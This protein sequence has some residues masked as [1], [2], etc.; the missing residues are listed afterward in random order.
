LKILIT[1]RYDQEY[2]RNLILINGLK[3]KG[4]SIAEAPYK[5][6]KDFEPSILQQMGGPFDFVF[7]PSFTHY[8]VRFIRKKLKL[9]VVFDPLISRYLTKVGDYKSVHPYSPRAVK[10]FLKDRLSMQAA[11]IVIADTEGHRQYFI[12]KIGISPEKIHVVPV[13]V[14]TNDFN[15]SGFEVDPSVGSKVSSTKKSIV[16]SG[17]KSSGEPVK[18]SGAFTVGFYGTYIPLHGIQKII[19]AALALQEYPDIK[20]QI[21]GSGPTE[22]EMKKLLAKLKPDN[23][24]LIPQVPYKEL[25]G[26]ISTFDISLG[27]FGDS[28]KAQLVIPNKIFHYCAMGKAVIT[29]ESPAISEVFT[30]GED[31]ITTDGTSSDLAAKIL[32]LKNKREL[33]ESIAENG[34]K[35]IREKYNQNCIAEMF[36]DAVKEIVKNGL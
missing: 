19:H 21:I 33:R 11:D 22:G 6:K 28:L 13:G 2:N 32:E 29:M 35:L 30:P 31:I 34:M 12:N 8:D 17:N 1:G 16:H 9:P 25:P 15:P 24:E 23:L 20:F 26:L 36:L 18:E 10:N 4:V 27:I 14:D 3:A 7:L 5:L